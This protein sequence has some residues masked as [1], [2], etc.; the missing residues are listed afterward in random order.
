MG[1]Y[2]GVCNDRMEAQGFI[3]YCNQGGRIAYMKNVTSSASISYMPDVFLPFDISTCYPTKYSL[4]YSNQLLALSFTDIAV[5]QS[6]TQEMSNIM[7]QETGWGQKVL[8]NKNTY[9]T[10]TL[11]TTANSAA[12][13]FA[14]YQNNYFVDVL[15][16]PISTSS[17]IDNF[18]VID[19]V[20]A[21]T[22]PHLTNKNFI[23]ITPTI[24]Q[25]IYALFQLFKNG[26]LKIMAESQHVTFII[27]TAP[28]VNS[29]TY[30]TMIDRISNTIRSINYSTYYVTDTGISNMLDYFGINY[31]IGAQASDIQ[32]INGV[33]SNTRN[34]ASVILPYQDFATQYD[35]IVNL[36]GAS[37]KN[38]RQ[39]LITFSN[40]PMWSVKKSK[41]S[42]LR[43]MSNGKI[44][45]TNSDVTLNTP[46][47]VETNAI[48][49]VFD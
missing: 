38:V 39:R 40:L 45:D 25:E 49:Q 1:D 8:L 35:V 5:L 41:T 42:M 15:Y 31:I 44:S 34:N 3:C 28:N 12:V 36:M 2:G 14:E 32:A 26:Q 46:R 20:Y 17:L 22:Q 33:I 7:T 4:S 47:A 10:K 37:A 27:R 48:K 16:G 18:T 24:E 6:I 21:N 11:K 19:P 9:S 13:D 29:S 30:A 43:D 23:H